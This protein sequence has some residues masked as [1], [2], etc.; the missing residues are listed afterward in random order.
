EVRRELR[1]SSEAPVLCLAGRFHPVKG[2]REMIDIFSLLLRRRPDSVLMMLGDGPARATCERVIAERG[3]ADSVR[4]LGYRNDVARWLGAADVVVV[5]SRS[6]G[7]CRAAIE[8]NLC[9]LPAVAY[10]VGGLSEALPD[11]VC[12]WLV[13]AGEEQRFVTAIERA[14]ESGIVTATHERV[15]AARERF[16]LVEHVQRLTDCYDALEA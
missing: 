12:G 13:P 6:E 4:L 14:L 5:P 10:D 8:G 15:R 7:L 1:V 9:G 16:G 3:I 11:P 2:H